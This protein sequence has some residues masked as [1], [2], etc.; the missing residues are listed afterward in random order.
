MP[1]WEFHRDNG[2]GYE[3]T[4]Y[5]H[6]SGPQIWI[7]SLLDVLSE[8]RSEIWA[9]FK[10]GKSLY[11]TARRS[12]LLSQEEDSPEHRAARLLVDPV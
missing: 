12:H 6:P 5:C 10:L 7:K 1:L 2:K 3:C 8:R 9:H 11:K 4:H